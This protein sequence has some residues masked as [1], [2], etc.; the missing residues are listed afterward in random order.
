MKKASNVLIGVT[1]GVAAYKILELLRLLIKKGVKVKVVLTRGAEKFVTP[2]SFLSL[3]AE[4]VFTDDNQFSV[5]NGSSIHLYL[6]KWADVVL[7]APATADF[8]A[9][10]SAGIADN[11]LSYDASCVYKNCIVRTRN[12][13]KYAYKEHNPK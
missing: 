12:E 11:L 4:E 5:I 3:G 9:K 10:A 1:G 2:F 8:I 13:R 6:A 7:V